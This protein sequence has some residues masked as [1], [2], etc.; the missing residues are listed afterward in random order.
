MAAQVWKDPK[1][2]ARVGKPKKA[3]LDEVQGKAAP[4]VDLTKAGF[5]RGE[6]KASRMKQ[7]DS[8][9]QGK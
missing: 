8:W 2:R 7:L 6:R 4:K 5:S 3:Q 1:K 9:A